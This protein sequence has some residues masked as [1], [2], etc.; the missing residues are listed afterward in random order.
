MPSNMPPDGYV[1]LN[2]NIPI[3]LHQ[4][5]KIA[6]VMTRTP[7]GDLIKQFIKHELDNIIKKGIK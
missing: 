1:R 5:L 4:K 3:E 7:M 6:S 2:A